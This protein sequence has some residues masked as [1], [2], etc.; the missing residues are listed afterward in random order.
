M[1][2]IEHTDP[3]GPSNRLLTFIKDKPHK[4]DICLQN[5][6]GIIEFRAIRVRE[7]SQDGA[8]KP[9]ALDRDV[10]E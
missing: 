2:Q 10:V 7:L 8:P 9:A 3:R 1:Q 5:H 6:G 4:G